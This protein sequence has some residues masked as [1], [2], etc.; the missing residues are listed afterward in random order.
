MTSLLDKLRRIKEQ[1][2]ALQ[3]AQARAS[4]EAAPIVI[5]GEYED[6]TVVTPAE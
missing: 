1:Q 4:R 2:Q 5:E 3:Q 6:I